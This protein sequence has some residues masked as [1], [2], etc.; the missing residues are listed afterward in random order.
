MSYFDPDSGW[1]FAGD[2][3]GV[4][5]AEAAHTLMPTP[6]PDIQVERW[7]ES[8]DKLA[9]WS[10]K[11]IGVAHFGG[12]EDVAQVRQDARE[13]LDKWAEKAREIA[14]HDAF[15]EAFEADLKTNVPD[16]AILQS[17]RQASEPR[18]EYPGPR[19]VLAQAR[20]R[21]AEP[22]GRRT[23]AAGAG[24]A[25]DRMEPAVELAASGVPGTVVARV[26][27]RAD[28]RRRPARSRR[29]P[30]GLRPPP[31]APLHAAAPGRRGDGLPHRLQPRRRRPRAA[32]RGRPPASRAA[33]G[34]RLA[35]R[36]G[37]GRRRRALPRWRGRGRRRRAS[38][39][40]RTPTSAPTRWR[41]DRG[42]RRRDH[43]RPRRPTPRCSSRAATSGGDDALAGA[44]AVGHLLECAA[45]VTRRQLR[46]AGRRRAVR[47][48]ARA[49]LGYPLATLGPTAAPSCSC[50]TARPLGS[51]R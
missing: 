17:M 3:A 12:H 24:F 50:S 25:G 27:G 30:G 21:A 42:G 9:A 19:A 45:Q 51:T 47:R 28:D 23:I 16:D 49:D 37:H 2:V 43:H 22:R 18:L 29:R 5:V 33:S 38:G 4:R 7:H 26:P 11:G 14:D 44:L 6:P 40:A 8:L 31:G 35:D 48:R 1:V 20:T 46:A 36:R 13:Q 32:R 15:T 39:S 34:S 41:G 10:P